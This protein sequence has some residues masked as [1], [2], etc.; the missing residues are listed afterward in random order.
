MQALDG[1]LSCLFAANIKNPFKFPH[2]DVARHWQDVTNDLV[3]ALRRRVDQDEQEIGSLQ[4]DKLRARFKT[5]LEAALPLRQI[6]REDV[7]NMGPNSGTP[8]FLEREKERTRSEKT[9]YG[10]LAGPQDVRDP[11]RVEIH[12]L[13]FDLLQLKEEIEASACACFASC[14]VLLILMSL[15]C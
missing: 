13:A 9:L 12:C 5:V 15:F 14:L 3:A 1:S 7:E 11:V 10:R 8:E 4:Q 2:G 6:E